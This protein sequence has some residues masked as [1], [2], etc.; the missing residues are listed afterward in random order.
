MSNG[1]KEKFANKLKQS[2]T[3]SYASDNKKM[4][5]DLKRY[6]LPRKDEIKDM[7][8]YELPRADEIKDQKRY[9]Q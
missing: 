4:I 9:K 5:K 3:N 1:E 2:G 8:R 6:E 7:K